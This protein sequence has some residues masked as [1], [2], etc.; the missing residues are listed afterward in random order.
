[1]TAAP[2]FRFAPSPNGAL[3]LGHAYSALFTARCARALG[4]RVLLRIED[5]DFIRCQDSYVHQAIEDLA[6]LGFS[7][8]GEPR[9][10]S[11]HMATY[12]AALDRL[13][14]RGLLYPCF[15]S[16]QEIRAAVEGRKDWPADPDGQPL[17]PGLH[18]HLS[19]ADRAELRA[20]GVPFS[21]RLDMERAL[22]M[23][24]GPLTF[25]E[26]GSGPLGETGVVQADPRIWGDV[27]LG[28]KDIGVSYHIAVVVDDA[29][30]GVTH[31]TRGQDLFHA[32]AVHRLL[33]VLLGLPEPRYCHHRLISDE[34]GRK[35]SKSAG[36]RSLRSL[37]E[38]GVTASEIR[39]LLGFG[40]MA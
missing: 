24:G 39:A 31:V 18:R 3:H 15:A 5:I 38:A 37:R 34:T 9:R 29:L 12:R 6:W 8:E 11:Q 36:D 7:W 26:D 27:I 19:E 23:A 22:A 25:A 4:G 30:Q 40:D 33:Q 1:M 16:R 10:Q 35:L 21:L 20:R 2:I 13:A 28:R 17:Y 14:A 32:T